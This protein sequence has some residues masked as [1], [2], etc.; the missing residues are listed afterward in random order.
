MLQQ[1]YNWI[2]KRWQVPS[3]K[4][5]FRMRSWLLYP[6]EEPD[7]WSPYSTTD[8]DPTACD[9]RSRLRDPWSLIARY[10]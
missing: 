9:L 6:S 10:S 8:P 4:V 3:I 1:K 5:H 2:L 7:P